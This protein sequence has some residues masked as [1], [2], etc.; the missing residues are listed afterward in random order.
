[1]IFF[2]VSIFFPLGLGIIQ[3]PSRSPTPALSS[4]HESL[5][6]YKEELDLVE[7]DKEKEEFL[8]DL[9]KLEQVS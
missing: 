8:P 6:R 5:K 2:T 3:N 7:A 9:I 4:W 1:M